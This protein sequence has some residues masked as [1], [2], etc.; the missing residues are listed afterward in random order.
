MDS[1]AALPRQRVRLDVE[2]V[3][4]VVV[5]MVMVMVI[6]GVGSGSGEVVFVVQTFFGPV[7]VQVVG[8]LVEPLVGCRL[9]GEPLGGAVSGGAGSRVRRG[10]VLV[11]VLDR[12]RRPLGAWHRRPGGRRWRLGGPGR[13][14]LFPLVHQRARTVRGHLDERH[15]T[16][17]GV[18]DGGG[19]G[20]AA[21][22]RVSVQHVEDR[23]VDRQSVRR[24]Y[25][26]TVDDGGAVA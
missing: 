19:H 21:V 11:L 25:G 1:H 2:I 10:R 15:V 8:V 18:R 9:F 26:L 5:A 20:G 24:R 16:R 12:F 22:P 14:R 23:G 4:I 13:L 6:V 7:E 17:R 3:V